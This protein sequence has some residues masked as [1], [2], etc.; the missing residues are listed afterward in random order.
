MA[1]GWPPS[2]WRRSASERASAEAEL[3]LQPPVGFMF[4]LDLREQVAEYC[5]SS[6]VPGYLAGACHD[7]HQSLVAHGVANVVTG[8]PTRDDTG[9]LIG[10]ITKVLT[11]TLVLQQVERGA[12]DLAERVITYLP[13]FKLTSPGAAERIRVRNLLSHTN[14]IDADLFF[15]D[16]RVRGALK[17]YLDQLGLHCGTLFGPDEYVSYSN[18]GMIVAGRQLEVVTGTSCHDLLERELYAPVGMDHSC[19]SAEKAILRSTAVATSPTQP[20][21]VFGG[22][23]CSCCRTARRLRAVRRSA[24]LVTF[25]RWSGRISRSASRRRE[26]TFWRVSSRSA[27]N[28]SR[29]TCEHRTWHPSGSV[30]YQCRSA[31]RPC[32]PCPE[33]R[34]AEWPCW[35]S[36]LN[37][38][39]RSPPLATIRGDGT[40]RP[41][42]PVATA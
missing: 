41:A 37:T 19:T 25:L 26:N 6:K 23:T 31:T 14:G 5:E 3:Y 24:S 29:T 36:Y 15:P 2:H 34:P 10:S 7:G 12:I 35:S 28:P 4:G 33:H 22:R 17:A 8:A 9:F 27:C 32:C 40:A 20:P 11:T 16:A 42:H 1:E 18:G 30:G 39:L 21:A 13:E 38:I